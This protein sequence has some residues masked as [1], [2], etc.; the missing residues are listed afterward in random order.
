MVNRVDIVGHR[1]KEGRGKREEERGEGRKVGK[2]RGERRR[3]L[4]EGIDH[5]VYL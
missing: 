5:E 4:A 1:Q 2:E 3:G